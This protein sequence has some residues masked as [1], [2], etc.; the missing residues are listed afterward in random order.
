MVC[1]LPSLGRFDKIRVEKG[2][3]WLEK[4]RGAILKMAVCRPGNSHFLGGEF[5]LGV[6]AQNVIG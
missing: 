1:E 5:V 2:V 4:W 6:K 3:L